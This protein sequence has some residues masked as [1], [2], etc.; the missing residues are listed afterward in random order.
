MYLQIN[1]NIN[2][3]KII[4]VCYNFITF[5]KAQDLKVEFLVSQKT[6][7]AYWKW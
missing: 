2:T 5:D 4:R 6:A 1:I 3:H 7:C